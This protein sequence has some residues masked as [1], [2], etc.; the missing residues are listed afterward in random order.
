M[1]LT[2]EVILCTYNGDS[3]IEEQLESILLQTTPVDKVSIYDDVSSDGTV[4]RINAFLAQRAPHVRARVSIQ[5]NRVNLGYSGNFC[6]AIANATEDIL[7]LCDQDDVWQREKVEVMIDLFR[8]RTDDMIC[9][10]GS[11][12]D[13]S[14]QAID[15]ASVLGSYGL[16][17]HE[18]C[19]FG[20]TAFAH[21]V[22]RN[23]ANGAASA[24][25]RCAAQSAIPPP[26]DMPHDYWL[27][28]WCSMHNGVSMTPHKLYR[29]RQHRGNVIGIGTSRRLY[30]WLG[31]W[32]H[33]STPRERE[34]RIWRAV[35][36]RIATL[37]CPEEARIAQCKLQWLSQV[38]RQEKG[39]SWRGFRI[40]RAALNGNYQRFSPKGAFMRDLISLLK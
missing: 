10:D 14:G 27:A 26:C 2:T 29:Y 4:A 23:Y 22:R 1:A 13:S 30:Q 32:R 33:P 16:T 21:L 40:L 18:I 12:I 35:A 8:V 37:A 19:S 39:S 31:M 15:G 9:S 25:R 6:Q 38:V 20:D 28:L 7:F 3:Y 24:I 34:L 17:Q 11:L 36:D 5:V